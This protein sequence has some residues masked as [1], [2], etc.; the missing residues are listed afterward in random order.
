MDPSGGSMH[1]ALASERE[2]ASGQLD[3]EKAAAIHKRIEK[4]DEAL[5]GQ[6]ELVRR[7][8]TLD[9]VVLQRAT[10]E[11]TV[12]MFATRSGRN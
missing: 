5:R 2:E 6:P 8:E 3:F 10:Q 7:I 11:H 4:L 12:A 1:E 9:A